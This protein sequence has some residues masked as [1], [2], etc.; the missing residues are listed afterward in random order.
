MK[1]CLFQRFTWRQPLWLRAAV[2]V[3][4]V[5]VFC[6]FVNWDAL[7]VQLLE[8]R[9]A[10]VLVACLP[11]LANRTLGAPKWQILLRA[12][13][14]SFPYTSLIRVLWVS[15]FLG[16]FLPTTIGGDSLRM[17][18]I[19]SGSDR[20]PAAISTIVMERLTGSMSLAFL[21]V[22][23]ALWIWGAGGGQ[24]IFLAVVAPLG[25]PLTG[26]ALLWT[27][28]GY[29]LGQRGLERFSHVPG[30]RVIAQV[31]E[32]LHVY[33]H[34]PGPIVTSLLISSVVHLGRV[35]SVCLAAKSL[36]LILP[37][38]TA[39]VVIP[40]AL[41][42]TLLPISLSGLG[43]REGAFVLMLSTVGIQLPAALSVSLISGFVTFVSN[44]PGAVLWLFC[45]LTISA[46]T[47]TKPATL[48]GTPLT[49]W[50]ATQRAR[51]AL[52]LLQ[53]LALLRGRLQDRRVWRDRYF[54]ALQ[55]Q[56][57]DGPLAATIRLPAGAAL[58]P[59]V[60]LVHGEHHPGSRL[61]LYRVLGSRLAERGIVVLTIDLPGFGDSPSP[62]PPWRVE[63]FTG[64][65]AVQ[66]AYAHLKRSPRIDLR[67]I[68]LI[69]HSFGGSVVVAAALRDP[70]IHSVIALGPTRR[71]E[72][73][74]LGRSA[75]ETLRW[76]ARFTVAR[77]LRPWPGLTVV[78][79]VWRRLS[80]EYQVAFWQHPNHVPLLLLDGEIES[81]ED[82]QFLEALATQLA[83]PVSYRTVPAADHYLNTAGW[84]PWVIYDE[85]AVETCVTWIM[86]WIRQTPLPPADTQTS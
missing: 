54:A 50:L 19:A 53:G 42:A 66:T 46:T 72:E 62:R 20:A 34:Q 23:G 7:K 74:R 49:R 2:S 3:T 35:A 60:I 31:H 44:L 12:Q 61:G 82:R 25:A 33:Q 58:A 78:S 47:E 10:W 77:G 59:A 73:R 51:L 55:L 81:L 18:S 83:P 57:P 65:T 56:T 15:N 40:P 14:L 48:P 27:A 4:L 71:V 16:Y 8:I 45:G 79:E 75:R 13:R 28:W 84:G 38:G 24:G 52:P 80:L 36:G 21:A 67:R 32:A 29:E 5:G 76:Q 30:Y 70:W 43:V 6:L 9:W 68:S 17:W 1:D 11:H 39:I 22:L 69:G 63:Q 86:E 85:R 41:F 26:I 37:F 64:Y